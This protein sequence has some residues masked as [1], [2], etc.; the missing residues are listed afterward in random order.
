[1]AVGS[2]TWLCSR[3]RWRWPWLG[4]GGQ[5]SVAGVVSNWFLSVACFH[6]L[7]RLL[8]RLSARAMHASL[9]E[10]PPLAED[11]GSATTDR[12]SREFK[13]ADAT[14]P[15]AQTKATPSLAHEGVGDAKGLDSQRKD[16]GAMM[17]IELS[18][19]EDERHR[20]Q[21]PH[22][23]SVSAQLLAAAS[24]ELKATSPSSVAESIAEP[25]AFTLGDDV[26]PLEQ[27]PVSANLVEKAHVATNVGDVA[28]DP[29]LGDFAR[30]TADGDAPSRGVVAGAGD[31]NCA[32]SSAVGSRFAANTVAGLVAP[33]QRAG[34]ARRMFVDVGDDAGQ[35]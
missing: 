22:L 18:Y 19:S 5:A 26:E 7:N 29:M 15:T 8:R 32:G 6:G 24:T 3:R 2:I 9:Q 10:P 21:K 20:A 16:S 1:M 33:L 11:V 4:I 34:E 14:K 30:P 12:R 23:A 28:S 35:L 31:G 13:A 17:A 27:L 25:E